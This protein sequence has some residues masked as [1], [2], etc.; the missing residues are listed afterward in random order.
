MAF[1]ILIYGSWNVLAGIKFVVLQEMSKSFGY[2]I[3]AVPMVVA[4]VLVLRFAATLVRFTYKDGQ[5]D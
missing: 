1:W 3:Y 4:G 5:E 2:L